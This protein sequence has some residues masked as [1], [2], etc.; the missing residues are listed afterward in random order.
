MS[1]QPISIILPKTHLPFERKNNMIM[2]T[3]SVTSIIKYADE[4]A[5]VNSSTQPSTILSNTNTSSSFSEPCA[6]WIYSIPLIPSASRNSSQTQQ[7]C[8]DTI[9]VHDY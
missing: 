1:E 3:L 5:K 6:D 9:M 8:P 2:Q 4:V 7:S